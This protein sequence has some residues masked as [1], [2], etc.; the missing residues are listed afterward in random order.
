MAILQQYQSRTVKVHNR[1]KH[2]PKVSVVVPVNALPCNRDQYCV[3]Q[4][5][6]ISH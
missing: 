3:N 5:M 1:Y 2:F 4:R 6:I